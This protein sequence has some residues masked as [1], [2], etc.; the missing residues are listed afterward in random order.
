VVFLDFKATFDVVD[1]SLLL[2]ILHRRGCPLRIQK[3]IASLTFHYIRS[4]IVSDSEASDWFSRSRGVLQGSPLLLCYL[5]NI[6]VDGLLEDLNDSATTVPQSLFYTDD[7]T[8]LATSSSEIQRLLDVVAAWLASYRMTLNI[9][10]CGYIALIEDQELVHLDNE[11]LPRLREYPYLGFPTTGAR[12]D[13]GKHLI[14]RLDQACG[15]ATF[16]S[17]HSDC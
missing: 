2:D 11:E 8:L 1:H 6:F 16:L 10:K 17:L 15:R 14:K 13:F 5:F 9:K 4:R 12:I 3:L 7:D